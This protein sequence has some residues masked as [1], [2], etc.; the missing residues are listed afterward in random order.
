MNK[1]IQ[2]T[3]PQQFKPKKNII[4]PLH[5]KC[6]KEITSTDTASLTAFAYRIQ[7]E[8]HMLKGKVNGLVNL[9]SNQTMIKL[10]G[11]NDGN[12]KDNNSEVRERQK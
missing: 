3:L 1:T 8:M 5:E 12:K 9:M 10:K 2:H 7:K 11:V 6:H 4:I